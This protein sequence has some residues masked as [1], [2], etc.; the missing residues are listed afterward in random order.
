MIP[1]IET[2]YK[3]IKKVIKKLIINDKVIDYLFEKI[4]KRKVVV[5]KSL[6]SYENITR[7]SLKQLVE[8]A[9]K[10]PNYWDKKIFAILDDSPEYDDVPFEIR[11]ASPFDHRWPGDYDEDAYD[12]WKVVRL[13][14]NDLFS[15][16]TSSPYFNPYYAVY[17]DEFDFEETVIN[18]NEQL[19][20][21]KCGLTTSFKGVD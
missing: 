13:S 2:T 17:P 3:L 10:Y 8:R 7:A 9:E 14:L 4:Q 19:E 1:G 18:E 20:E 12:D 21:I 6:Y 16:D 15:L 5:M 11:H